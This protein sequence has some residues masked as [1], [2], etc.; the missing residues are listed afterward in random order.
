LKPPDIYDLTNLYFNRQQQQQ[1][2]AMLLC[3]SDK[4]DTPATYVNEALTRGYLTIYL[5]LTTTTTT[6]ISKSIEEEKESNIMNRGNL[7]TFD[8]RTFYNFALAGDLQPFEELKVLVEEALEE[9]RR[10]AFKR[11]MPNEEEIVVLVVGVAAEL[12]RN[13]KFE[14]AVK[15]EEWWQKTYSEWVQKGLKVTIICPH[16][17]T[18]LD[19]GEFVHHKNAISSLHDVVLGV[20]SV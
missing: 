14:E 4:H 17:N 16:S 11:G 18:V 15:L 7:L 9:K 10:I 12:A 13:G 19:N 8:T 2:H 5:P 3:S 1:Q 20:D 6:S